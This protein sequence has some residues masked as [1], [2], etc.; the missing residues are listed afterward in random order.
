MSPKKIAPNA[1]GTR[2]RA[3]FGLNLLK[4]HF[5]KAAQLAA[6]QLIHPLLAQQLDGTHADAQVLVDAFA[7]EMIRHTRK[8]DLAMQ[9]LVADTQKRAI[10]HPKTKAVGGD[11]GALHVQRHRAALA[12]AALRAVV[13]Q[14]LPVAVIGATGMC[15]FMCAQSMGCLRKCR[16][17]FF[18]RPVLSTRPLWPRYRPICADASCAPSSAGV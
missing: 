14:Q 1:Q 5:R 18:T 15:I 11:G 7:V 8:L 9:R 13:G 3:L 4:R 12:E 10:R 16:A 2:A 17:S 6:V